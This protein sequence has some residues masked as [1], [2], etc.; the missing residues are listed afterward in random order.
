MEGKFKLLIIEDNPAHLELM[1]NHLSN[2]IF[3]IDTAMT[4]AE[5]LEKAIKKDYDL[6][7]ID[8]YLPDGNGLEVFKVLYQRN[9]KQKMIMVTAAD[10]PELSFAVM[11][12]GALDYI[13]KSFNFYTELKD[14]IIENLED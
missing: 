9:P 11:K 3:E 12:G 13:V 10:D 1:V 2:D 7:I 6:I 4:K 8:Y 14:R 5:A